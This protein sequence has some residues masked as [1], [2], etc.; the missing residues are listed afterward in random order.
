MRDLCQSKI[1]VRD[2]LVDF[3]GALETDGGAVNACILEGKSHCLYAIVVAVL[4]LAAS[5]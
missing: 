1:H 5:A 3:L 4:K 2:G